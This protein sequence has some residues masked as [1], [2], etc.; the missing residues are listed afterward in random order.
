MDWPKDGKLV[1]GEQTGHPVLWHG[2]LRQLGFS[3]ELPRLSGQWFIDFWGDRKTTKR[4]KTFGHQTGRDSTSPHFLCTRGGT[5]LHT[6]P[7]YTRYALQL[8]LH[9]DGFVVCG[10]DDVPSELPVFFPGLVIL[11]DTWSPHQVVRDPRLANQGNNKLL[12]GIDY[13]ERPIEIG[14]ELRRLVEWVPALLRYRPH[15]ANLSFSTVP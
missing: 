15:Q 11:L 6:D 14:P 7:G 8:Q 3:I 9:N 10:V 1:P 12:C 5:G 13:A 4:L 2:S